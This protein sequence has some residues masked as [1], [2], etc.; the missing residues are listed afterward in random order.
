MY[1]YGYSD[2]GEDGDGKEESEVPGGWERVEMPGFLYAD[3]LVLSGEL[4]EHLKPMVGWFA[5]V[6]RRR[7]L[8]VNGGK[9]KVLVLNG[10]ERLECEVPTDRICLEHVLEFKHLGPCVL[11]ESEFS[12]KV[13]SERRVAGAI[14]SL[15]NARDLQLQCARV[16]HETLLVSVLMYSSGTML[17]KEKERSRVRA[18]KIEEAIKI[19]EVK[20]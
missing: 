20:V 17:W 13:A 10:E 6:C 15:V 3:N 11:D 5:E 19:K 8:K 1:I 9:S 4:E 7:G 16:L 14:R 2:G 12:R 18:I